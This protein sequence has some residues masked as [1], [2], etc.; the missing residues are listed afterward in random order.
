MEKSHVALWD[1]CGTTG[2]QSVPYIVECLVDSL[3]VLLILT[4]QH[5][6]KTELPPSGAHD[7]LGKLMASTSSAEGSWLFEEWQGGRHDEQSRKKTCG[8]AFA[9]AV[10]SWMLSARLGRLAASPSQTQVKK[11]DSSQKQ[12]S[13]SKPQ[14]AQFSCKISFWLQPEHSLEVKFQWARIG[15]NSC[16]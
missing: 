14:K 4:M 16:T 1:F 6:W 12:V 9:T 7:E 13:H 2:H 15:F 8:Q 11:Q 5:H 10:L 3:A